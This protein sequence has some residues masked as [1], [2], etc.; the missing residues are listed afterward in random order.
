MPGRSGILRASVTAMVLL[1]HGNAVDW[2]ALARSKE[3]GAMRNGGLAGSA[4][5]RIGGMNSLPLDEASIKIGGEPWSTSGLTRSNENVYCWFPVSFC[6][7]TTF[8]V[9]SS[10]SH[11]PDDEPSVVSF[12]PAIRSPNAFVAHWPTPCSVPQVGRRSAMPHIVP[13]VPCMSLQHP[14]T[15][16]LV[17]SRRSPQ[18]PVCLQ[19]RPSLGVLSVCEFRRPDIVSTTSSTVDRSRFIAS[20]TVIMLTAPG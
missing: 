5:M 9:P 11:S 7:A 3:G 13:I 12:A 4:I 15:R 14:S 6:T 19:C 2:A 10:W 20:V 17:D 18:H 1:E 16:Q 8:S